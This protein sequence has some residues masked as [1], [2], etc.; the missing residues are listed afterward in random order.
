MLNNEK[1]PCGMCFQVFE[2]KSRVAAINAATLTID[3]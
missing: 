1:G 3:L 2:I